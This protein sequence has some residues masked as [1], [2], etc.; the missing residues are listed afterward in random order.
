MTP[1]TDPLALGPFLADLVDGFG[2]MAQG[3][4]LALRIGPL[5]G[6]LDVVSDAGLLRSLLQN[7]VA[8]ALRYT[9]AGGVLVG[10]RRRRASDGTR[11]LRVDVVDTGVGIPPDKVEAIFGEFTRLGDVEVEG[12]GLGLALSERIARLLGARI[13]VA[14]R[15][16]HGSRFSLWLAAAGGEAVDMPAIA[17]PPASEPVRHQALTVL[18]I[19]DDARTVEASVALLASMG[20]RPIGALGSVEALPHARAADAALVD[21]RLDHGEDGLSVV[22]ALRALKPGLP[23][24]LITAESGEEMRASAAAMGV[25]VHAKP[26]S[27][28]AIEQFLARVAAGLV[29]EVQP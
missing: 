15:P 1:H 11:W 14:S 12:L 21:Y 4:G 8:N 6:G 7:F 5:G 10:V 24:M 3:K 18:A 22:Q 25:E 27:P 29:G 13:E 17:P 2:P 19:D 9:V 20:H 28:Q 16:G 26:A 23:A